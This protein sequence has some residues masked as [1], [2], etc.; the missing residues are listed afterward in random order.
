MHFRKSKLIY[1]IYLCLMRYLIF[2]LQWI[3]ATFLEHLG[4]DWIVYLYKLVYY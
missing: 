2:F 1:Q 3:L 4:D